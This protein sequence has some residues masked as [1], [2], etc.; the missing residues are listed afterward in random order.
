MHTASKIIA[1]ALMA[2]SLSGCIVVNGE[3]GWAGSS[4]W[5][6]EQQDNRA[7]IADLD[8]GMQRSEV[9]E[10]LGT[11]NYSEAFT[12]D[13]VEYRVLRFRTRHR[14]SDGDTTPDETTPLIFKDDSL[15]GWGDDVL[16]SI[17]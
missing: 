7:A 13:N 10:R 2:A 8:L 11:P 1:A 15:I 4:D 12:K 9:V 17:R 14:H 5:K 3:H 6:E 16:A